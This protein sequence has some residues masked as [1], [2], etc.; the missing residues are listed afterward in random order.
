MGGDASSHVAS[1]PLRVPAALT[2]EPS[3]TGEAPMRRNVMYC[4]AH[5]WPIIRT[6][7]FPGLGRKVLCNWTGPLSLWPTRV[8]LYI[9]RV[10]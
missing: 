4:N 7:A 3:D 1:D 2:R 9:C 6:A 5:N 10:R 8:P